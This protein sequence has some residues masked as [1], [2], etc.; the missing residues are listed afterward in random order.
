MNLNWFRHCHCSLHTG[1]AV[2]VHNNAYYSWGGIDWG[3]IV[4]CCLSPGDVD[5]VSST[6]SHLE[7]DLTTG[8]A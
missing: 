6:Q 8:I 3:E 7:L 1:L 4:W 5:G 2:G